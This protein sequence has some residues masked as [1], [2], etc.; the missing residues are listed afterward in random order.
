MKNLSKWKHKKIQYCVYWG[1]NGYGNKY[2]IIVK[3]K[4]WHFWKTY[5]KSLWLEDIQEIFDK[6]I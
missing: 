5:A 1:L 6:N 4:W 3:N 2:R